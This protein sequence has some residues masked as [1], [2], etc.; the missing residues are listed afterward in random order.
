[1]KKFVDLAPSPT[2]LIESLRNIGYSI[3]TSIAD[4]VDNSITAEASKIIIRFSWNSGEPWLA[5]IDNGC[6]MTKEELIEAMRFGSSNPSENR[7]INDMGRF[8]LG[9]KTA[10]L[11][12]C[13]DLIVL[14]KKSGITW[15]CE[16]NLD[17]LSRPNHKGWKLGVF[18]L[19]DDQNYPILK[20]IYDELL[21]DITNGT[22]V[23]WKNIDRVKE[24]IPYNQQEVNFNSLL[25]NTRT[26]LELTFHRF[27]SPDPGTKKINF[28]MN[29][30]EL[31]AFNPFNPNN[32]ATQELAEQQIIIDGETI[33]VQPYVLPHHNKVSQQEYEKYS[34]EDGY[35]HNQGFY[36]YRNRRLI[37]KGT[38]FNLIRKE[39]LNKLIR[40][41][42]DIPNS[43]DYLWKIDI[44]KSN[45]SPPETVKKELKQ[46]I[47]RIQGYGRQVYRQRGRRLS[48][49]IQNP[50]WNRIASS[51]LIS[52]RLNREHPLVIEFVNSATDQQKNF[53]YKLIT[54]FESSFPVDL[55][56]NDLASKPKQIEN[57]GFKQSDLEI[58]LDIFFQSWRL[59][60]IP[61]N[62]YSEKILSTDPFASNQS[63]TKIILKS[64]GYK[65]E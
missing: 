61:E 41:R 6:G 48:T 64:R 58:L 63:V 8:G 4:I 11:S 50:V 24:Q 43:L 16:W 5:I 10:S 35:L 60:G 53:F 38:W 52:Y 26:H 18:N 23:F 33:K 3:Q 46:V 19:S 36:V 14:S 25:F 13:R 15:C 51:G 62:E 42:V 9:L 45:A 49:S 44:K 54:M 34:G 20:T 32:L 1:M 28:I 31:I 65:I 37:I 40:V 47:F 27:L 59:S 21:S 56:F 55:F 12:Q 22:I 30:D 17:E 7:N 2:S 57:P 39:E 29:N